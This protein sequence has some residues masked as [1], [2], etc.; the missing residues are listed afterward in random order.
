M[1]YVRLNEANRVA[2]ILPQETYGD[3]AYWYG[4]DFAARCVPAPDEVEE[5]MVYDNGRFL[6]PPDD[7]HDETD[8]IEQ[9]QAEY[10]ALILDLSFRTTLLELGVN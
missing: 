2:E 8:P 6:I 4:N 10:D 7:V 3:L 5:G 9:L 1:R